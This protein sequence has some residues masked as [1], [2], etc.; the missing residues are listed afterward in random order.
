MIKEESKG[1]KRIL[2]NTM[3]LYCRMFFILIV[4]LFTSR[5]LLTAL[6][7]SDYGTY[8][9][10]GGIVT[11]MAFLNNAMSAASSRFLTYEL[12]TGNQAQLNKTFSTSLNLHIGVAVLVI[13]I[14]IPLGI[15]LIENKL[16][17]PSDRINAAYYILFFSIA[18]TAINFTQVP[19]SASIISHEEMKIYAYVG[20]YEAFMKLIIASLIYFSPI[21]RLIFYG[22]LLML[23]TISIQF[24]YRIYLSKKYEECHFRII[25]DVKLYKTLLS[26]TGWEIFGG[27]AGICQG[28]GLN[29]LLNTFFG[30]VV[31]AARAFSIQIQTALSSFVQNFLTASRPQIVKNYASGNYKAMY[32]LM[33]TTSKLSF[34]LMLI[35]S[36]PVIFEMDYILSLWLGNNVPQYTS[37]FAI[38]ILITELLQTFEFSQLAVFHAIGRI[39]TG[40]IIG[41]LIIMLTLPVSY[42]FLKKGY[43]PH[44]VFV[45][46]TFF[47][48]LNNIVDLYLIHK[49]VPFRLSDLLNFVYKPCLII[50]IMAV[51]PPILVKTL[52]TS[53]FLRLCTTI[54][55]TEGSLIFLILF[56]AL[57]R[58]ER[59]FLKEKIPFLNKKTKA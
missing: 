45:L 5:I 1:N 20:L 15:W 14:G 44:C 54:L 2:H 3:F 42:F 32:N 30:P 10:V 29:I 6:G 18:S 33:Y 38:L 16:I 28:Q 7:A 9:V 49:Y 52:M 36:L 23:N 13:I 57:N 37:D 24:F 47:N 22:F 12:G 17:I 59:G 50:S 34:L 8:N 41:G 40:S 56:V 25:R 55:F 39:K 53:S 58:A 48:I 4:T 27:V 35:L 46:I 19:Y 51:I 21:D 11:M 31:N 26:Y 43:P